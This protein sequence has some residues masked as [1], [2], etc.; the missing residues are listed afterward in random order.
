MQGAAAALVDSRTRR[1]VPGGECLC[2]EPPHLEQAD[3]LRELRLHSERFLSSWPRTSK[4]SRTA[5]F[6]LVDVCVHDKHVC[7][8]RRGK[9]CERLG[10]STVT[11]WL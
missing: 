6:Q 4:Q 8:R 5:E 7:R 3:Q 1:I 9:E 10:G 2:G 11:L